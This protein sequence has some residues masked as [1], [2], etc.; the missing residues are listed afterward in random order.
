MGEDYIEE[1]LTTNGEEIKL[2]DKQKLILQSAI[3]I[4]S[5]KGFAAT[6]TSE[7]AK[8]AGVAEGTIFKHYNTKKDLLVAIVSPVFSKIVA[9]LL[10]RNFRKEIFEKEYQSYGDFLREII[11]NR[12]EFVRKN[13]PLIRILIQEMAFHQEFKTEIEKVFKNNILVHFKKVVQYFKEK[14][15]LVDWPDETIIRFTVMTVMSSLLTRLVFLSDYDWD[16][17]VEL[18]R[19]I[20]FIMQGLGESHTNRND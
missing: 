7:I 14:G 13:L 10:M 8:R 1:L 20:D 18:E 12:I 5:Q 19:T 9:P 6:S 4:F 17:E 3:E 2:T 11:K 16:D 15:D